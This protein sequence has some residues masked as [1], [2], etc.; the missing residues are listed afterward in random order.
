MSDLDEKEGLLLDL[1]FHHAWRILYLRL[2][3]QDTSLASDF[4]E[5]IKA[6]KETRLNVPLI[7]VSI[8]EPKASLP[9][10]CGYNC[11]LLRYHL[12]LVIPKD[13]SLKVGGKEF[14]WNPEI[15]FDDTFPHSVENKSNEFRVILLLDTVRDLQH[16]QLN[17]IASQLIQKC[18]L[19]KLVQSNITKANSFHSAEPK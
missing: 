3:N 18:Q 11:L 2:C 9:E 13:C 6:I 4:P 8:L 12:G 19:S 5:T 16:D 1:D 15:Y 14:T 17:I 7:M 10:H